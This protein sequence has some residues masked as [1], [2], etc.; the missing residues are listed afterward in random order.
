MAD[1]ARVVDT[2]AWIEWLIGSNIGEI[3]AKELPERS[4]CIVPTIV[5][6]ELSK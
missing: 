3:L 2:S 1:G 6:L 4:L 5:Q